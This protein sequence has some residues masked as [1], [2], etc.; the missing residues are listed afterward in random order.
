MKL[1]WKE[2]RKKDCMTVKELIEVLKTIDGN[3]TVL[4]DDESCSTNP[5][6]IYY[7]EKNKEIYL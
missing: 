1:I 5:I 2:T 4:V 6:E 3:A 7:D